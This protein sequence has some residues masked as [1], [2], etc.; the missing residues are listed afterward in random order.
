MGI[1]T[2]QSYVG[3]QIFEA[4]GLGKEVMDRCS[5]GTASIMGGIGFKEIA[6]DVLRRHQS[7]GVLPDHGRVRYR[8]D[9]EDHG[10]S[11]PL[12]RA[13]QDGDHAGF[14][15]RVRARAPAGPRDLLD[16]V[17]Q[18]SVPLDEVEPAEEIPPRFISSPKSPRAL[19]PEADQT[20]PIA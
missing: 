12:V 8:R 3:A 5:T 11:P 19:S 13:L 17:E 18:P 9:G 6:E 20:P 15:E 1:S 4:I 7:T 10:W 14:D 16:F 2:L